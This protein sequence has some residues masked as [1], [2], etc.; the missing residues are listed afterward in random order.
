MSP[1][2]TRVLREGSFPMLFAILVAMLRGVELPGIAAAFG[3]IFAAFELNETDP[4]EM[5]HQLVI[6]VII[7]AAIGLL[8]FLS[9]FI[10][11]SLHRVIVSNQFEAGNQNVMSAVKRIRFH[12][13]F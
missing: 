11:V 13:V 1:S 5:M 8:S 4:W 12:R 3:L 7:F 6:T 9:Q 10:S 2:R